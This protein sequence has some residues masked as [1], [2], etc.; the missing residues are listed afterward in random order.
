MVRDE[1]DFREMEIATRT[2]A[3]RGTTT[4]LANI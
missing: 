3:R 1:L 4:D 2:V